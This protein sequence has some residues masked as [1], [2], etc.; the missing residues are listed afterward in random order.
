MKTKNT[1]TTSREYP[2]S[3]CAHGIYSGDATTP[4]HVHAHRTGKP[5]FVGSATHG[6]VTLNVCSENGAIVAQNVFKGDAEEI[7]AAVNSHAAHLAK[8]KALTEALENQAMFA[9]DI[10][11]ACQDI[12]KGLRDE[13]LLIG[14]QDK[15]VRFNA[16]ARAALALPSA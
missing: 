3:E 5:W 9:A 14:L 6:H 13:S 11:C 16:A 8:I 1:T 15:A 2:G 4:P 7:V 12:R 10:S